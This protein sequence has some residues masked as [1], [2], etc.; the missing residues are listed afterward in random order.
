MDIAYAESPFFQ[1]PTKYSMVWLNSARVSNHFC[2]LV[3]RSDFIFKRV[4]ELGDGEQPLLRLVEGA[5]LLERLVGFR[6]LGL[7]AEVF[8]PRRLA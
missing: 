8:N 1:S 5:S 3:K 7:C 4:V 2:V 6:K